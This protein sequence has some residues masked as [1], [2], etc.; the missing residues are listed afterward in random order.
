MLA[1]NRK[2]THDD[3]FKLCPTFLLGKLGVQLVRDWVVTASP[4]GY[5]YPMAE[6]F[7]SAYLICPGCHFLDATIVIVYLIGPLRI[8]DDKIREWRE[9]TVKATVPTDRVVIV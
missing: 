7:K 4:S 9:I 6:E 8:Q 1:R 5:A 2:Y 3:T